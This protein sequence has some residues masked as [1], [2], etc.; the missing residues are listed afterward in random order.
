MGTIFSGFNMLIEVGSVE[1][2]GTLD[3]RISNVKKSQNTTK[4]I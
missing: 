3:R 4:E 2:C 1:L